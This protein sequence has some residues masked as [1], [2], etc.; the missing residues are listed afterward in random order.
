MRGF[1]GVIG[2]TT[3]A[4][5]ARVDEKGPL[6]DFDLIAW[7]GRPVVIAFDANTATNAKVQA[8]RRL[9]AQELTGR[10]AVVRFLNIPT[11]PGING[12]DDY[13]G[14]YGAAAFFALAARPVPPSRTSSCVKPL[15]YQT[16]SYTRSSV[17]DSCKGPSRC[18]PGRVRVARACS[19]STRL[20]ASP[21]ANRF[22]ETLRDG[23]RSTCWFA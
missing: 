14:Q 11:E 2:K 8:A 5:G 7:T 10:G 1:R 22:P 15:T 12:P 21:P 9:L 16:R 6:P 13:I 20:R 17:V 18:W 4:N 23:H 19:P 3:D